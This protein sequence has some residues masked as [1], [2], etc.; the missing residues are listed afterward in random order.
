MSDSRTGRCIAVALLTLTLPI[1][2][3]T[4]GV[5]N[6]ITASILPGSS[7]GTIGP[8]GA[9]PAPNNDNSGLASPNLVP[10]SIVLNA[11]G[12]GNLDVE[13]DIDDSAGTTEYWFTQSLL[14]NTGLLWTGFHYEL[15]YGTGANFVRSMIGDLDF[16]APN[17]DP[18]PTS[19]SFS[20]L[21]LQAYTLNWSGG[22]VPSGNSLS[23]TFSIDVPDSLST[24]NPSGQD[25]F[26]LRQN[27]TTSSAAIPEPATLGLLVLGLAGLGFSRRK[28]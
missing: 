6:S 27:P 12:V 23:Q 4:A 15:G 19:S 17:G 11:G 28:R 18:V 7:T 13:F 16:D 22:S 5:I 21:D 1:G 26:T 9:T 14:N 20:V 10:Y 3:A 8:V 2:N 25:R 24:L